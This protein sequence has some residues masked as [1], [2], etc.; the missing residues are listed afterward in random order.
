MRK[1]IITSKA[2]VM[3]A[4]ISRLCHSCGCYDGVEDWNRE[5]HCEQV[6]NRRKIWFRYS[7]KQVRVAGSL[8]EF[9]GKSV[10]NGN[11]W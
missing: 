9:G 11:F 7:P 3:I 6:I 8:M 2:V 4:G 5:K 1:V 10:G